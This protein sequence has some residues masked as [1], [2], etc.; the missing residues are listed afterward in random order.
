MTLLQERT[1]FGLECQGL[2]N[3]SVHGGVWHVDGRNVWS[4]TQPSFFQRTVQTMVLQTLES[5]LGLDTSALDVHATLNEMVLYEEGDFPRRNTESAPGMFGTYLLQ[6]PV[7]GG[8][9]GAELCIHHRGE[10]VTIDTSKLSSGAAFQE[11]VYYDDC[12]PERTP[13]ARGRRCVLAFHLSWR[14]KMVHDEGIK[15]RTLPMS[16]LAG[17]LASQALPLWKLVERT[18]ELI[19]RWT[20]CS[21]RFGTK[22]ISFPL[23]HKHTRE[24]LSFDR[25]VGTDKRLAQAFSAV[26]SS[27]LAMYLVQENFNF[28][29]Q[30]GKYCPG[31]R[32]EDE[33]TYEGDDS[34]ER[35]EKMSCLHLEMLPRE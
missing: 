6:L 13:V 14:A 20:E 7:E 4:E 10:K 9:E 31:Y 32:D 30:N 8:H 16:I 28:Y 18:H 2:T 21:A 3:E 29:L 27:K 24:S 1:P 5:Q 11:V 25:L 34:K 33:E 35:L 23:D 19:D 26:P 17:L 15:N 22:W 12:Y